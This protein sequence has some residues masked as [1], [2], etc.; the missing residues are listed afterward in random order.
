MQAVLQQ[1]WR[2]QNTPQSCT[3]CRRVNTGCSSR[4]LALSSLAHSNT[5]P[6]TRRPESRPANPLLTSKGPTPSKAYDQQVVAAQRKVWRPQPAATKHTPAATRRSMRSTG[7]SQSP[8]AAPAARCAVRLVWPRS[9]SLLA[10]VL[11]AL[12]L[13]LLDELVDLLLLLLPRCLF[14]LR[15]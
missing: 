9:S 6:N 4:L 13:L 11:A 15:V 14:C 10:V 7:M 1:S 3:R 5:H 8:R 2:Q 12:C